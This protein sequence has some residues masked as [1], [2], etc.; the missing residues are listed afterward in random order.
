M[1]EFKNG[2]SLLEYLAFTEENHQENIFWTKKWWYK[3]ILKDHDFILIWKDQNVILMRQIFKPHIFFNSNC[4]K[5]YEWQR[6]VFLSFRYYKT[7]AAS[8]QLDQNLVQ[9]LG[10]PQKTLHKKKSLVPKIW[11]KNSIMKVLCLNF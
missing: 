7:W 6:G 5:V 9:I 2:I 4:R 8:R 10:L 11:W 3:K 1:E